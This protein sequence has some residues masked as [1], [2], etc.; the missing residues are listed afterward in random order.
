M[1]NE[2]VF[3]EIFSEGLEATLALDDVLPHKGG[4]PGGAVDPDQVCDEVH[5][6]VARAEVDLQAERMNGHIY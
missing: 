6:R 2:V 5:A 4:H 3:G 1:S